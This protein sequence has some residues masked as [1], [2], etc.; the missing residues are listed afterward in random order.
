[1]AIDVTQLSVLIANILFGMDMYSPSA[2]RLLLG[3]AAVESDLGTY[4]R[5]KN[6]PALGIF[7]I[8]PDTEAWL[9]G[10]ID[11]RNP[12]LAWKIFR[13]SGVYGVSQAALESNLA[14]QV[15]L[16]RVNYYLKPE[17]LPEHDDVRGLA[18]Y[19]KKYWNTEA[20]RGTVE[21]F[22]QKYEKYQIE[23]FSVNYR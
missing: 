19:W 22:I 3:T 2:Q 15:A 23:N 18:G 14:Y 21:K 10:R 12:E 20:G 11:K 8:E 1:M 5:Q 17:K 13:V 9:W 4:I 6:G 7:Q 16:A